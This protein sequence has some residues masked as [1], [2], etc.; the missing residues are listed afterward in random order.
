VV[1]FADDKS[2]LVQRE[3]ALFEPLDRRHYI[4]SGKINTNVLMGISEHG[5]A[6]RRAHTRTNKNMP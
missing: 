3:Q 4:R 1:N 2:R 6:N 5:F